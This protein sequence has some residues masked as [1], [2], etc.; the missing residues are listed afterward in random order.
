MIAG[1]FP[2]GYDIDLQTLNEAQVKKLVDNGGEFIQMMRGHLSTIHRVLQDKQTADRIFS[3]INQWFS[4]HPS[5]SPYPPEIAR[6][7]Y[8]A[9]EEEALKQVVKYFA[10]NPQERDAVLIF[11]SNHNFT[12]YTEIFPPKC[13]VVPPEFRNARGGQ[14]RVGPEGF[15]PEVM[16]SGILPKG[17]DAAR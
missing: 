17:S 13:I 11:G 8:G 15:S 4:S 3:P 7:I 12:F 16:R 14:F 9:R 6:L 2:R 1:V 5:R 10:S